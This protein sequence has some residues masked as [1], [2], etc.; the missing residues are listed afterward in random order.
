MEYKMQKYRKRPLEVYAEKWHGYK[1]GYLKT[2]N[3][4][5]IN[6]LIETKNGDLITVPPRHALLDTLE[7]PHIVSPGDYIVKGIKGEFYPVKDE[8]FNESYE[9]I[10]ESVES[11]ES[12]DINPA[13]VSKISQILKDKGHPQY[14][15]NEY[16]SK[17]PAQGG[18]VW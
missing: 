2:V 8:I 13:I 4:D 6:K 15:N 5:V 7:G 18:D 12:E 14:Q 3:N 1:A 17:H 9:L 10:D 11:V 16:Y